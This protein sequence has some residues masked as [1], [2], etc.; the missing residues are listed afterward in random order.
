VNLE[1]NLVISA[2][3]SPD[4]AAL[5]GHQS[6]YCTTMSINLYLALLPRRCFDTGGPQADVRVCIAATGQQAWSDP[7][8]K[9][10]RLTI[11]QTTLIHPQCFPIVCLSE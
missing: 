1:S 9:T 11:G 2:V 4:V 8:T 7:S 3:L 6:C 10:L 5:L